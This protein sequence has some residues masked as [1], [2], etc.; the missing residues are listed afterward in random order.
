MNE[1]AVEP[2]V[3]VV[4]FF[5]ANMPKMDLCRDGC[6]TN[7][8]VFCRHMFDFNGCLIDTGNLSGL[9]DFKVARRFL[10]LIDKIIPLRKGKKLWCVLVTKDHDFINDV[11]MDYF[12]ALQNG[13]DDITLDFSSNSITR[14]A[15]EPVVKIIILVVKHKPYGFVKKDDLR[16]ATQQLSR[17]WLDRWTL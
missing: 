5:D 9:S 8:T 11:K 1:H 4:V 15:P 2:V 16:D 10:D 13:A 6:H 14:C 12:D 7:P 3:D 17:F